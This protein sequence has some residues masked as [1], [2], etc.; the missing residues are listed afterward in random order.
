LVTFDE[1]VELKHV[2]VAVEAVVPA[3]VEV[4]EAPV[5]LTLAEGLIALRLLLSVVYVYV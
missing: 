2:Q 3:L 4:E 5:V 1:K